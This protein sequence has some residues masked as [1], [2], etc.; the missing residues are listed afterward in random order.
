MQRVSSRRRREEAMSV[1]KEVGVRGV[2]IVVGLVEVG[3][4]LGAWGADIASWD[5]GDAFGK[6]C[7]V[8]GRVRRVTL[9]EV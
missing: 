6:T 3:W 1:R 2:G 4:V 8:G 9:A 7:C 5:G